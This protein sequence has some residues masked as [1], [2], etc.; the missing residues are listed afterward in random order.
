MRLSVVVCSHNSRLDYLHR[1]IEALREQ[2][3]SYMDWELVVIDNASR[4]SLEGCLN[5]SGLP[6]ARIIRNQVPELEAGLVDARTLGIGNTSGDIIVFVDDDNLLAPGF[7]AEALV[8]EGLR[9]DLGAWGGNINLLYE[10]PELRPAAELEGLLCKREI[11]KPIWSNVTDHYAS[12]PWGAGLCIRRVVAKAH[13]AKLKREPDRRRLDPVGREMRFGGDTDMVDTGLGLGYGKGVFPSL[14]VTHLI[15]ARR[16]DPAFLARA[17][18]AG[19]YS[20]ALHGW[21]NTGLVAPPRTDWRYYLGEV[22][23]MPRRNRWERLIHRQRR[24]G[25][26]RAYHELRDTKPQL[27]PEVHSSN[28]IIK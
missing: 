22:G 4:D 20:A 26:W 23:R 21:L 24:S 27:L 14:C 11:S 25:H 6:S 15:P 12:T 1:V 13:V 17:L 28:S 16:C 19:G 7:L 2:V 18:E 5:L 3:L 10:K 9:P 8:I